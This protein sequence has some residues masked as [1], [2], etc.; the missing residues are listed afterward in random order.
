MVNV[1]V[2]TGCKLDEHPIQQAINNAD[3]LANI[4]K[5]STSKEFPVKAV[6]VFP[7]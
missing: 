6:I 4:L 1:I 5:E 7:G 2:L 3:W